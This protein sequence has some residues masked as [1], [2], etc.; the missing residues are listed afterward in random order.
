[1]R[2]VRRSEILAHSLTPT[3]KSPLLMQLVDRGNAHQTILLHFLK[4][5]DY[6]SLHSFQ[7]AHGPEHRKMTAMKHHALAECNVV[8][9]HPAY[10]FHLALSHV[11]FH[12]ATYGFVRQQALILGVV[13]PPTALDQMQK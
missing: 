5:S 10:G 2:S 1:M 3:F 7:F 13:L 8:N 6:L 4:Q 9:R 12:Q 11:Y